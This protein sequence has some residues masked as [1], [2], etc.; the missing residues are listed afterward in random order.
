MREDLSINGVLELVHEIEGIWRTYGEVN[1][2]IVL[3]KNISKYPVDDEKFS[4]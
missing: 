1:I 4:K 3:K 2:L